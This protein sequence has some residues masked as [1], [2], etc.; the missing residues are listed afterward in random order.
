M[1]FESSLMLEDVPNG[2]IKILLSSWH[3]DELRHI[4]IAQDT[5]NLV[6]SELNKK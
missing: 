2:E 5:L 1:E 4:I 6:V 3:D